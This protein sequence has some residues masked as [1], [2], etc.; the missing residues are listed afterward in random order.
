MRPRDMRRLFQFF[1]RIAAWL[2]A[3]ELPID[4]ADHFFTID[5]ARGCITGTTISVEIWFGKRQL[6]TMG[7]LPQALRP[8]REG[9]RLGRQFFGARPC[10]QD[11]CPISEPA[12]PK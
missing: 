2:P 6:A 12:C 4:P 11:N 8:Y 1:S 9:V 10:R 3:P 5:A 7:Q